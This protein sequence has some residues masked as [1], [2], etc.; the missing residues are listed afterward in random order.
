VPD[1]VF[2]LFGLAPESQP[3]LQEV[4]KH[5]RNLVSIEMGKKKDVMEGPLEATV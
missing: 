4:A 2:A 1:V 3:G 5:Y